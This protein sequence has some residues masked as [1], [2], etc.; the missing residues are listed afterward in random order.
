MI[1]FRCDSNTILQAPFKTKANKHRIAAYTS[2]WGRLKSLGH[3]VGL[4]ILDKEASAEY[5]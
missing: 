4:Q 5:K 1:F 2:I 3:K